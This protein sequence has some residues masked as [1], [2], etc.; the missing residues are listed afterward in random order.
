M[1]RVVRRGLIGLVLMATAA[2]PIGTK[3]AAHATVDQ[4]VPPCTGEWDVVPAEKASQISIFLG[5]SFSSSADGWGVGQRYPYGGLVHPLLEH[6]DGTAWHVVPNPKPGDVDPALLYDVFALSSSDVWA[7]GTGWDAHGNATFTQHWDG[8]SW[9]VVPSPNGPSPNELVSVWGASPTDVWAVGSRGVPRTQG[10]L[11]EHWDGSQWRVI[12]GIGGRGSVLSGVG[13]SSSSDV[14]AVG[15]ASGDAPNAFNRPLVEHWDGA[16]WTRVR[17]PSPGKDASSWLRAVAALSPAD[18]WAVGWVDMGF[19]DAPLAVH[20]DGTRWNLVPMPIIKNL[21]LLDV[22]ALA[23]DDVWAVGTQG[24]PGQRRGR[25]AVLHWNGSAWE[26]VDT[27]H[28]WGQESSILYS[29]SAVEGGEVWAG[30]YFFRPPATQPLS[31][32]LCF[33]DN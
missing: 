7:V 6:W 9:T 11:I 18:A 24:Q 21:Q 10:A 1:W 4:R 3:S 26:R 23:S 12:R 20:W 14:W 28:P 2:A 30:G 5:I 19:V 13:G 32:H 27:P 17:V 29:V 22:A 31:Q 33:P 8:T 25:S 15:L 16:R